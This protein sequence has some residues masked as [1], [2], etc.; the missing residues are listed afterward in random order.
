MRTEDEFESYVKELGR[1]GIRKEKRKRKIIAGA[2]GALALCLVAGVSLR[3]MSVHGIFEDKVAGDGAVMEAVPKSFSSMDTGA[4]DVDIAAE[5]YGDEEQENRQ[6]LIEQ[7]QELYGYLGAW[8]DSEYDILT[9][10]GAKNGT[11]ST[12]ETSDA[13][14]GA[15]TGEVLQ[16]TTELRTY[17]IVEDRILV[18]GITY[19]M[20]ESAY[21]EWL[22][23]LP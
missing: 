21:E 4:D 5:M 2:S 10:A 9:E 22:S 7:D 12:S 6:E 3:L 16:I 8:L 18:E 1:D 19:R 11:E 15:E 14:D 13:V 20:P 17:I 23:F